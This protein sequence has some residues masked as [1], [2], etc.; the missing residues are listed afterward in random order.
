MFLQFLP[1][2]P[3]AV[4]RNRFVRP[5]WATGRT[6]T[7]N[8]ST[9]S[10]CTH[11][12]CGINGQAVLPYATTV[13]DR[14]CL[15]TDIGTRNTTVSIEF[16]KNR[17]GVVG[18]CRSVI[19]LCTNRRAILLTLETLHT[20]LLTHNVTNN[21]AATWTHVSK[22]ITWAVDYHATKA[23]TLF[24]ADTVTRTL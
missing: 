12:R 24:Y 5:S 18:V 7:Y 16:G 10:S 20:V 2:T 14:R 17:I 8:I 6:S 11:R 3:V 13:S 1:S 22:R 19:I 15:N 4:Y 23:S 21:T 9:R